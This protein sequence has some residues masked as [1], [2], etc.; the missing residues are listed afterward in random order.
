MGDKYRQLSLA[1][2]ALI[3]AKHDEGCNVRQIASSLGRAASRISR[4]LKRC[5]WQGPKAVRYR[6]RWTDGVN[7][8]NC[9]LA[10]LGM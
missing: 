7:G 5:G 4:E 2:R 9:E 3:Q 10:Q 8:Y 6:P 1:E